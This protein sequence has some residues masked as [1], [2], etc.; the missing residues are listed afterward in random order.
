MQEWIAQILETPTL[1]LTVLAAAFLLGLL[2]AVSSCCGLPVIAAIAGYS[3]SQVNRTRRRDV[4]VAGLA[5]MAGTIIALAAIGAVTGFVSQTV[6]STLGKYW[7]LFAGLVM[8]VFGLAAL[9]FLPFRLRLPKFGS[10]AG[11]MPDG[12]GKA[13]MYGLAIGGGTSAC[14]AGCSPV[15]PVVLGVVALQGRAWWGAV[16]L[17]AFA[18]GYSLPLA[19][20]LVGLSLGFE[21]LG[22]IIRRFGS[23]IKIVA[24]LLLIGVGFYLLATA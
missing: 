13:M 16:I 5:F 6:G 15:L 8:V 4:W 17:S 10:A 7:Q 3:G 20:G 23:A 24:G 11:A 21:K 14:A 19:G 18:I 1:S 22:S 2:G 9:G 12:T